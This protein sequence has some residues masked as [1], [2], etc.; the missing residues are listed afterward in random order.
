MI[1][2]F[3]FLSR[4]LK[5]LSWSWVRLNLSLKIVVLIRLGCMIFISISY[6][7]V[8]P[9]FNLRYAQTKSSVAD[10][11]LILWVTDIH[12]HIDCYHL[13]FLCA[14][15]LIAWV[16]TLQIA[17]S[18]SW[19]LNVW[20]W[21][22]Y[23]LFTSSRGQAIILTWKSIHNVVQCNVPH[24]KLLNEYVVCWTSLC[25]SLDT[26]ELVWCILNR[27]HGCIVHSKLLNE[28]VAYWTRLCCSLDTWSVLYSEQDVLCC[29]LADENDCVQ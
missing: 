4:L 27:E 14:G 21:Y 16:I 20:W 1:A 17:E 10:M 19:T 18:R 8:V 12:I 28:Y 7:S 25:W 13:T 22:N 9:R 23:L 15:D 29:S 24:M 26:R 11:A 5:I 6:Q 3:L 2:L